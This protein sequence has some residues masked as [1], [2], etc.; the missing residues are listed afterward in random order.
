MKI[1]ALDLGTK[2]GYAMRDSNGGFQSGTW[3]LSDPRRAS[4][5][6][7]YGESDS[8]FRNLYHRLLQLMPVTAIYYED[9]QFASS[10]YQAQLWGGFRAI[11][12]LFQTES[13]FIVGI[14]VG[15]LKKFVTGKGNSLK[16]GMAK[17]LL[18]Q[19]PALYEAAPD[20]LTLK[21]TNPIYVVDRAAQRPIDDNEVDAIHLLRLAWE[22]MELK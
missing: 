4:I 15:T 11:V 10:Q 21:K 8:R 17:S 20:R 7:A 1:L 14:P 3:L 13:T 2:T 12:T 19:F 18:N 16:A 5:K 22:E 6:R 9:V